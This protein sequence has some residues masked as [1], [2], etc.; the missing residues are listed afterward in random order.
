M[1]RG[2]DFSPSVLLPPGLEVGA[3][4]RAIDY[5]ERELADLVESY[6]E[7]ANQRCLRASRKG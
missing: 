6:F 3:I 5:L 7:Q 2:G 4:R 1:V